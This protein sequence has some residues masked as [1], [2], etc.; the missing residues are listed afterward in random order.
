MKS[1]TDGYGREWAAGL[2][3]VVVGV[4]ARLAFAAC[5]PAIPFFD[6]L[7]IVHFG[8]LLRD[9][10]LFAAGWYWSQFNPGLPV[11]MSLLFRIFPADPIATARTATAIATGL[12]PLIPFL[13]WR[14]VLAFRWRLLA[15]ALLASWPGQIF[16]SGAPALDNWV[17]LPVIGLASLAVRRLLDPAD[18]GHP[19]SSGLLYC[20]AFVIRQEMAVVLLPVL[21]CAAAAR[22]PSGRMRRNLAVVA[23]I[24]AVAVLGVAVQRRAATGRFRIGSEHGALGLYGSFVPSASVMGWI[25]ARAYAAAQDPSVIDGSLYGSQRAYLR[26]TLAEAMRRPGFHL[27]RMAAWIPRL[28]LDADADNLFWSVG[29]DRAQPPDRREAARRFRDRW[30]SW[31]RLEL[32]LVQGL[33]VATVIV[34]WRRRNPA[35]LILAVTVVLKFL[36][37][38]VVSP[39]GRLVVPALALELLT[40]PLGIAAL[41]ARPVGERLRFAAFAALSAA[42]LLVGTPMLAA[43]VMSRDSLVLPGV[44]RFALEAGAGCEVRCELQSGKITGLTPEWA[45]LEAAAAGNSPATVVRVTCAVP[46]LAS[47]ESLV[48]KLY[49]LVPPGDARAA[50]TTRVQ[51]DG[52]EP[53]PR[54][55]AAEFVSGPREI[56]IPGGATARAQNA[57]VEL[58]GAVT[59]PAGA[60]ELPASVTLS[61][62]RRVRAAESPAP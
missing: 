17:M 13:V 62:E 33:F 24:V 1:G 27:L 15:G 38:A 22:R 32:A 9:H 29:T 49:D 53:L 41:A 39:V 35:I 56:E 46:L 5:Y 50:A 52:Q 34:G 19:V 8:V 31:L 2:L 25:D 10:G 42:I 51:V 59:P 20:A 3:L 55:L 36:I 30:A 4:G 48:L 54:T 57:M 18:E 60:R 11:L 23:A 6:F 7:Q 61:F 43:F 58:R 16:F 14:P 28:A 21:L 47:D 26:L 40:I 44:R 45:R 12:L 37:H